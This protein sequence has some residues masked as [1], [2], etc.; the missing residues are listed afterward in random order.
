MF[1]VVFDSV[2]AAFGVGLIKALPSERLY[3]VCYHDVFVQH[4]TIALGYVLDKAGPASATL[5]AA[6]SKE[7]RGIKENQQLWRAAVSDALFQLAARQESVDVEILTV[8]LREYP[9]QAEFGLAESLTQ[10]IIRTWEV[11]PCGPLIQLGIVKAFSDFFLRDV[12]DIQ[13][14]KIPLEM[15]AD[16]KAVMRKIMRRNKDYEGE[17]MKYYAGQKAKITKF[18]MLF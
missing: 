6:L 5:T 8:I 9:Y 13:T 7:W 1:S 10:S 3:D 17:M 11:N 16:M 4:S 15:P 2:A 12:S 14:F 18:S